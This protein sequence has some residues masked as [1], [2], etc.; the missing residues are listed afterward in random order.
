MV[1]NMHMILTLRDQMDNL[2]A[3]Y[4]VLEIGAV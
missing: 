4:S 2:L 1:C 3:A